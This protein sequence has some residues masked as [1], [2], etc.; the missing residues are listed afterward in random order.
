M[1]LKAHIAPEPDHRDATNTAAAPPDTVPRRAEQTRPLSEQQRGL[2]E[3]IADGDPELLDQDE[4][5]ALELGALY[6]D[7]ELQNAGPII[8]A[9]QRRLD[10]DD[11]RR[12]G[13]RNTG[14]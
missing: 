8:W 12:D 14:R 4:V 13:K 9:A 10:A 7:H 11:A 3:T 6:D 5:E 2:L 1:T